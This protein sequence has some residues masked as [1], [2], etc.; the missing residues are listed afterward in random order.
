MPDPAT[1]SEPT[2]SANPP[3]ERVAWIGTGIM[4][5]S[6]AGH[7]LAA[8]H[9]VVV[10]SRTRA[11]AEALLARGARWADSPAEAAA[12][13]D[14]VCTNVGLPDE[15]ESVYFGSRGVFAGAR[16]GQLLID[17]STSPP[18]LARRIAAEAASR[19]AQALDAPVSGG[20]I[21]A[22]NAALVIMVGGDAASFE[23]AKPLFARVGKSA[24]LQGDAGAGQRTKIV[25]QILVAAST[26][27]MCEAVHFAERA[28]LDPRR[29]LESIGGG[30]AASWALTALAPRILD[31]NFEPGFLVDHIVKDL[32]IALAEADELGEHLPVARK[33]LE[34]YEALQAAGHGLRGTQGLYLL[35]REGKAA[36]R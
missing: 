15:I 19:G 29:V 33:C 31:G 8:G 27:G 6:M 11:K 3:A 28:G 30:A 13:A 12:A 32:R 10:H 34:R 35:Y 26:V 16:A 18:S 24:I 36:G 23:R 4:G 25:N 14:V 20:D 7:L 9:E 21:G 5:G 2:A 1:P 17:F 22:R